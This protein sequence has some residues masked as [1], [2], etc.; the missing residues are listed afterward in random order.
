MFIDNFKIAHIQAAPALFAPSGKGHD[1]EENVLNPI[2]HLGSTVTVLGYFL[3]VGV[4]RGRDN[5]RLLDGSVFP[6]REK[7]PVEQ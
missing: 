6:G 3:Y 5:E 1:C 2:G 4:G 7:N